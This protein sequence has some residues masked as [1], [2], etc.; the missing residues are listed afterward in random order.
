M[1][2]RFFNPTDERYAERTGIPLTCNNGCPYPIGMNANLWQDIISDLNA[3]GMSYSAIAEA[4]GSRPSTIGD[5]ATGRST[6]PRGM[7]A[8]LLMRL[9]E[10]RGQKEAAA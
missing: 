7:T 2:V 9:H 8:V 1:T 6:E 3:D 10:Q 5:I 4:V